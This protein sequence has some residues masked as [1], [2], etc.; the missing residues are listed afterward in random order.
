MFKNI[1]KTGLVCLVLLALTGALALAQVASGTISGI[2]TDESGAVIPNATVTITNK[3]TN[4]ARTATTNAEGFFSAPAL[5]AGDYDVRAEIKGFKTLVRPAQVQAGEATQVN[6]PMSLGATSEVVQV[7]A[8]SA[9]INYETN[10]IQGV[11]PRS[12][13]ENLPLNGRS[14][15]QLASIEPGV[16]VSAGTV[17]QFNVLFQVSVLGAGN[18]TVVTMD[19]GNI[20]DNIDVGGG[21]SSMNFSQ[22]VVQEFQLSEVNFDL[23]TP[24]AAGGA[25][26]VVTRSGSND[27]H[28]SGYFFFRDHNMAAYPELVKVVNP[29]GG[30][31]TPFF[32]RRNPGASLGGPIK[33]DK[34]FFFFNYEYLNQVQAVGVDNTDPAFAAFNQNYNSPYHSKQI[35]ARIDYHLNEKHNIFMRYSHDGNAGFGQSLLSGDPSSWPHNTNWADQGIIGLTSSLTPTIVNDLRFQYNYWGNH[36]LQAVPSD[37]A[38]PCAAGVLPTIFTFVGGGPGPVG[39]NFNAPQGRNTRRFEVV[40]AL[41]WQKGS[42]RLKFG[43]DFNPTGSIGE[44]GF[45]TPMCLGAFSP[46]YLQSTFGAAAYAALQPLLWPTTVSKVTN[47]TQTLGLPVFTYPASIF[48]GVGVGSPSLPGAY[49]YGQNIGYNQYRAYAQDVWKVKSNL[50]VNFGLAWNAQTGFYPAGVPLPQY[51]A[52]ILGSGNLGQTQNNTKEFQPAFGFAWSPF[53]NNK[54]VIRGGGGI[55]WDSTPG[56]YKLRSASSIDPPGAA[57]NTLAAS[58]FYNNIPGPFGGSGLLQIGVAGTC[59]IPGLPCAVIPLNAPLPLEGLTNMSV[60]QFETLVAQELPAIQA[61]ISPVNPQRSGPF[62]YANI[63]YAKQGVEIYPHSFPLARSYQTSLG[64]QHDLGGGFVITADWARR[65]GENVSLGEIDMNLF[66]RYQGSTTPV[67][68]IPVCKTTPDLNPADEC[69]SG[70]ITIWTDQGTAIYEGLLVKATK[71]FSHRNQFQVSYAFQH[72]STDTVDV[73]NATNWRAGNGQYLAHQNLNI[74]GTVNLPWHFTL[75][76]NSSMISATPSTPSVSTASG[77]ILPGTVPTG[78]SEPLP[79]VGIGN[80]GDDLTRSGLAAAVASYNS[81]IVGSVNAQGATIKDYVILPK[82]YTMGFPTLSQDF[83]LTYT[84]PIKERYKFNVFVEMFNAF[85]ISNLVNQ[86]TALD[87]S[88]SSTA[89]CAQGVPVGTIGASGGAAIACNFGQA[90]ARA[91]QTFGSAGPRAVQLGARFTF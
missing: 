69:S 17:A 74:A 16:T 47:A 83:R 78:G 86:T 44:W 45:C 64:I 57:R 79:G 48:S 37:C 91:G 25:I 55:Y 10:Q 46:T 58:D 72:A 11:I 33:K 49:D 56:Y 65:Q 82:N 9:Q 35:T 27:W 53:K 52:P 87:V 60:Q 26:N 13:I 42:H 31:V 66:S 70:A 30:L 81:T 24:I 19:G 41:S 32:A 28:G 21:M 85:N 20:S 90:N 40:E 73:W 2:V 51:L 77:L 5:Q 7:E 22:D 71:R 68:V 36:N 14:Y 84:L 75:S 4:I 63:N 76:L 59:P 67:P 3:A 89:Y 6:M 61:V 18:R 39:P 8:A 43:G 34:L 12:T 54:T 29:Q 80:L 88:S 62:P 50:T 15:L 23:A 1:L 38:S